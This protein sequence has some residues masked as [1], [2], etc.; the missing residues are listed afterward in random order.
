MNEINNL[1]IRYT[2]VILYILKKMNKAN[3]Q[4]SRFILKTG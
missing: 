2:R 3:K 4:K 1:N